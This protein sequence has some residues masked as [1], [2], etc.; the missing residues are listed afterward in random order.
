MLSIIMAIGTDS[1]AAGGETVFVAVDHLVYAAP[2]LDSGIDCIEKLTGIRAAIG[3]SH[4]GMGTRNAII[5][6]GP[7]TYLE[8]VAP[9]PAQQDYRGTR[10][11]HVD[12]I[13]KP[14]L[15]TWAAKSDDIRATAAI[16]LPDGGTTG[17]PMTGS[18]VRPDAVMLTWELTHPGTELGEG[19]VPFFID[20]GDTPHP[21]SAAPAGAVLTGLRAEHPR[22]NDVLPLL[23]ALGLDLQVDTGSAPAL[24]AILDTPQ[25]RVELR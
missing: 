6:L 15:I 22:P 5:A 16:R 10:I 13:D 2:D 19:V 17:P 12:E 14:R 24:I 23:E 20:W 18:R 8:I 25:G 7:A 9:D 3:G 4:P 11:F 21:A 1:P